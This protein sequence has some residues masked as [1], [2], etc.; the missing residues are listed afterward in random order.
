MNKKKA[1]NAMENQPI[2]QCCDLVK[3]YVAGSETITVLDHLNLNIVQHERIAI[4]GSSGSGKTTL[5]NVI[6]GLDQPD[7][8][9]IIFNGQRL[10]SLDLKQQALLRNEQLGFVYQFHHLLAEFTAIENVAMPLLMREKTTLKTVYSRAEQMLCHVGLEKRLQHKPATLSG[11]ERQ[12]VAIARALVTNPV[13]VFMDEPTGNL[14]HYTAASVHDL[15]MELA[16]TQKVSFIVVTHDKTLADKM[17][18][19]LCL[20]EG[21]LIQQ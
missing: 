12:R 17:D 21:R 18:R 8:G 11:G 15:M 19:V 2:L 14:D 9:E 13:L 3:N 7:E 6:A 4:T 1:V 10:S 20:T 16:D 5:L